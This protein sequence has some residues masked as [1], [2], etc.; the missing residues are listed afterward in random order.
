VVGGAVLIA[1][2]ASSRALAKPGDGTDFGSQLRVMVAV[3]RVRRMWSIVFRQ[4]MDASCSSWGPASKTKW[5]ADAEDE[6]RMVVVT[7]GGACVERKLARVS[8]P[9]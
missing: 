4:L 3:G 6:K 5:G 1:S 7:S 2:K 8:R 9:R